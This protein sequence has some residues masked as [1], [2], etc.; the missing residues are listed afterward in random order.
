MVTISL[1]FLTVKK[2]KILTIVEFI[3][4]ITHNSQCITLLNVSMIKG[5]CKINKKPSKLKDKTRLIPKETWVP[6][7]LYPE[8]YLHRIQWLN[9]IKIGP[10]NAEIVVLEQPEPKISFTTQPWWVAFKE[11]V[12]YNNVQLT[13]FLLFSPLNVCNKKE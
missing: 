8:E 1:K 10:K 5:K 4:I 9:F 13:K 7:K 3:W 6:F 12:N 2:D 11:P